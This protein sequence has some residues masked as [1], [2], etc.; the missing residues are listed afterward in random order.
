M[1][2]HTFTIENSVF[3]LDATIIETNHNFIEIFT[4]EENLKS[5][6]ARHPEIVKNGI[7]VHDLNPT[8]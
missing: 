7:T 1:C 8:F 5:F 4:S 2:N 6:L 3:I